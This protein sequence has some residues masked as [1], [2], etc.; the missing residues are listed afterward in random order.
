MRMGNGVWLH[1]WNMAERGSQEE[2]YLVVIRIGD[3][4]NFV[5]FTCV[6]VCVYNLVCVFVCL[7]VCVLPP[8]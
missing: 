8:L 2:S 7:C 1:I 6:C 4:L 5:N 3:L